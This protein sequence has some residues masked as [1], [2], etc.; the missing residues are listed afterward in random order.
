MSGDARQD[1]RVRAGAGFR[2]LEMLVS[3]RHMYVDD[4]VTDEGDRGSGYGSA[5]FDWLC[6]YARGQ[7]CV[8]LELDS[9]LQR[10]GAHRFYFYRGMQMS[11]YH[12]RLEL[13]GPG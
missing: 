2:I 4:L 10:A 1:V 5:L 7:G 6:V 13:D 11:S 8:T 3:G 9:G 12:F